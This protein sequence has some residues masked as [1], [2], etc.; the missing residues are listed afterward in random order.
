MAVL[1]S[2][3]RRRWVAAAVL[4]PAVTVLF[5]VAGRGT[6]QAW[7]GWP[8]AALTGVPAAMVLASY[9]PRPGA[10]R[11]LDVG[12]S[13]CAAVAALTVLLA[14]MARSA[15]PTDPTT[16]LIGVVLV[17]AGLRQR[18]SDAAVCPVAAGGTEY[19]DG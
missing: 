3:P 15:A 6:S 9:L 14:V 18:L 2:W 16:A 12:C 1:R 4:V 11:R 10:G 13:P 5:A 8:A 17:G 19:P 7:W